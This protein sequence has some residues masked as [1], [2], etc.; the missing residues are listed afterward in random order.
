MVTYA[1]CRFGA[2][3]A[4]CE[5]CGS[6]DREDLTTGDQG[7]TACCNE[8]VRY[9]RCDQEH[10]V[11]NMGSPAKNFG[12]PRPELCPHGEYWKFCEGTH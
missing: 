3:V 10:D 4:H 9:G 2:D 8:P 7:Y 6:T 1:K 5:L 12:R 11:R